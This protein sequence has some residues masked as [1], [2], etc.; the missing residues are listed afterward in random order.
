MANQIGHECTLEKIISLCKRRGFVYQASEI[1]GGQAGAWDYG[2]LGVNFKR[3]IQN[4]WWHYMTQL[5]DDVV[6]L[7][8]AIFQHHKTWEAS[9]HVAHFSDPM[10]DC[11]ECK[12]RFRADNLIE[13]FYDKKGASPEKPVDT[14]SQDRKSVV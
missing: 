8:S 4:E 11:T 6:G 3:N 7:D 13:E 2:P 1:Y 9:G 12:A 10:I 5:R 14:M